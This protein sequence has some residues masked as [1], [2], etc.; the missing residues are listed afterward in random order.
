MMKYYKDE[1]GR[2]CR[3]Y[4]VEVE[5]Y[6]PRKENDNAGHMLLRDCKL[7]DA[8]DGKYRTTLE[9]RII[10]LLHDR[11]SDRDIIEYAKSGESETGLHLVQVQDGWQIADREYTSEIYTQ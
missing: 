5:S 8:Y 2:V 11:L 7:G 1:F 6:D 9:G 10:M 3:I 4:P